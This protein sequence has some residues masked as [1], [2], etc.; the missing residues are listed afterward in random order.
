M[1]SKFWDFNREIRIQIQMRRKFKNARKKEREELNL[2]SCE[3]TRTKLTVQT[4][5]RLY[6]SLLCIAKFLDVSLQRIS[7]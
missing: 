5:K 3:C 6:Q 7:R 4:K 1:R 2:V